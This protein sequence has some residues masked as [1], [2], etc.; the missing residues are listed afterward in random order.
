M[1][2]VLCPRLICKQVLL[3]FNFLVFFW[4]GCC[5]DCLKFTTIITGFRWSFHS[6]YLTFSCRHGVNDKRLQTFRRGKGSF[7]KAANMENVLHVDALDHRL[8]YPIWLPCPTMWSEVG[9][10][11][12]KT[13]PLYKEIKIWPNSHGLLAAHDYFSVRVSTTQAQNVLPHLLTHKKECFQC[14]KCVFNKHPMDF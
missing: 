9:T 3:W 12:W 10:T 7:E 2:N 11:R 1:G 4:L 5:P 14:K 6:L 13:W 8:K